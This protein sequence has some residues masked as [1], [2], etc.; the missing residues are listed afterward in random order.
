MSLK[1]GVVLYSDGGCGPTNPGFM[2][3]GVHGYRWRE[4][5]DP[6]AKGTV[7]EG[8]LMTET[9]YTADGTTGSIEP[10][11]YHQL[12]GCTALMGTNNRAE[13]L[14]AHHALLKAATLGV[15]CVQLYT[16]SDYTVKGINT[17]RAAW[18]RASWTKPDGSPV[19]NSDLWIALYK[20]VDDVRGA[21]IDLT[22]TW[23][24]GHADGLGNVQADLLASVGVQRALVGTDDIEWMERPV[25]KFWKHSNERHPMLNFS[26]IYFNTLHQNQVEGEYFQANPYKDDLVIGKRLPSSGY[27][28]VRLNTPD[29]IIE[30]VRTRHCDIASGYNLVAMMKLDRVFSHEVFH[31]LDRSPAGTLQKDR[32]NF[33]LN[34]ADR[35]P[36]SL[37]I[38]P[39]GLSLRAIEAF[40]CLDDVLKAFD[41]KDH[42][43]TSSTYTFID[44][45]DTFYTYSTK[46]IKGVQTEIGVLNSNISS[47]DSDMLVTVSYQGHDLSIP[48][49]LGLDL[50]PRN[51]LKRLEDHL[52]KV[53]IAVTTSA[54]GVIRY[55]GIVKCNESVGIWSNYFS[56]TL[57]IPRTL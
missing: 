4:L 56:D 15:Q 28:I 26:R 1:T 25:P 5:A 10:L 46:K 38:N 52:P 47:A 14:G 21:G 27:S 51:A 48:I 43:D 50:P 55:A 57:F 18:E 44:V 37:E 45:S 33:N 11:E 42:V 2:G 6:T 49:S 39:T 24:K 34:F 30:M 32:R 16:D 36:V 9:G 20:T 54:P 23:V 35:R 19:A 53:W 31:Y 13:L 22:V 8:H 41:T 3:W 29:P 40:G 12:I 7:V 17:W